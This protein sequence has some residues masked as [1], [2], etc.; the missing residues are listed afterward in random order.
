MSRVRAERKVSL[1]EQ[2]EE[3]K[4][5]RKFGYSCSFCPKVFCT[6]WSKSE[7]ELSHINVR[8][9]CSECEK[10]F[11]SRGGLSRHRIKEHKKK[12]VSVQIGTLYSRDDSHYHCGECARVFQIEESDVYLKHL[13]EHLK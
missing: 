11:T 12:F 6:S 3:E 8:V 9:Q 7:H 2:E 13:G 1:K 4:P 5:P 10:S